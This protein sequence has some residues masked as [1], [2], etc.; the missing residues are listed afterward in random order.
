MLRTWLVSSARAQH[1]NWLC[2]IL[3]NRSGVLSASSLHQ[4][5]SSSEVNL[6]SS[7]GI[8]VVKWNNPPVNA[9][10]YEFMKKS[11]ATLQSLDDD[12]NCKAV[13]VTSAIPHIFCAGLDFNELIRPTKERF[14]QYILATNQLW[15]TIYSLK[16]PTIA[17]ING[18][19]PAGGCVMALAFDYRIMAQNG[20]IGLSE[21]KLGIPLRDWIVNAYKNIIGYRQ[22]ELAIMQG[23]LF[24]PQEALAIGLVDELASNHKE[25][26]EK[27]QQQA[28]LLASL[29]STARHRS[30]LSLRQ[31]LLDEV[32]NKINQ[33]E[34]GK[35]YIEAITSEEMQSHLNTYLEKLKKK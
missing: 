5:S 1:Q 2:H 32:Q 4:Y 10:G 17:A 18:S 26:L 11:A 6:D 33:Q 15:R 34:Q 31:P 22:A 35:I 9:L 28:A 13:I 20:T 14:N 19:A 12:L 25:L 8:A 21:V 3:Q 29:P 24:T 27:A 7:T 30:K 23:K 16:A